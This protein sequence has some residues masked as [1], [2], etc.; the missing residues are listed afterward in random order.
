M[1]WLDAAKFFWLLLCCGLAAACGALQDEPAIEVLIHVDGSVRTRVYANELTVDQMLSREG[2]ELAQRDRL[3]HPLVSPLENGMVITIR[4]VSERQECERR[5]IQFERRRLPKESLR[6]GEEQL[7]QVGASGIEEVC[8]RVILE[9]GVE[10]ERQALDVPAIVEA[11]TAEITYYGIAQVAAPVPV[12][13]RLSYINHGE[14]WT[15]TGDASNKRR[16]TSSLRLD[17]L[18]FDQ[19]QAGE[20]LLVS[21]KTTADSDFFNALWMLPTGEPTNAVRL[22]PTDVLYAEWR[23]HVDDVVAYSTGLRDAATGELRALN[24]LWLLQIDLASGR[25]LRINEALPESPGG[26]YGAWGTGFAWAPSGA[27]LAWARADGFGLVDL[28][29]GAMLAL[30][31]YAPFDSAANWTWRSTL[32]WSADSRLLLATVHGAPLGDEP[33]TASPVFDVAVVAADGSFAAPM[34]PMAG[35]WAAPTFSPVAA[36]GASSEGYIAWLAARQ[37]ETSLS[38]QYDLMI[39]DRDGSNERRL[40]PPAGE[41]GIARGDFTTHAPPFAWSP[42]ARH[43]AIIYRGDLWLVAVE[44][45]AATQ[46]TFDGA[47]THPAWSG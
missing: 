45:A 11:P 5:A 33:A 34:Q 42:D 12:A 7:G 17:S 41:T 16:L 10:A 35:M 24:N 18:V 44:S 27:N 37:P 22:T 26:A 6:P 28:A 30:Q 25:A 2:I 9:D 32:S 46:V 39:A 20:R 19:S 47:S 14:A 40:F 8:Y 31:S 1:R 23:P 36:R 43:I 15:I 29:A 38:S 4:R 13:G 21:A 3:S